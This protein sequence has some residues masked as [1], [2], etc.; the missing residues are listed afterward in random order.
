MKLLYEEYTWLTTLGYMLLDLLPPLMRRLF[1]HLILGSWGG[2]L[3]DRQVYFRYPKKI[4]IGKNC[5]INRGCR[6]FASHHTSDK[7]NIVIGDHVVFGPNVTVFSAGH[8]PQSI[9]LKDTYGRVV[10]ENDVWI[11][12][13]TTILQ[14][15]TIHQGAVVGAGSVVTRD[16][17]AYTICAGAPAVVKK[18]RIIVE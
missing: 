13:N 1:Y 9:D 3:I 17:P 16:I 7:T 2:G 18:Q 5:A 8:D 6:F 15:V 11:G 14:G 12:G 4:V 10:I